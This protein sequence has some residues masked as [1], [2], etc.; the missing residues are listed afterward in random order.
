MS[1][2]NQPN[3]RSEDE[4]QVLEWVGRNYGSEVQEECCRILDKRGGTREL[5]AEVLEEALYRLHRQD[6]DDAL[7][8][9]EQCFSSD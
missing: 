4:G 3:Q 5:C 9:G 6:V 8:L 2:I 1:S 7:M